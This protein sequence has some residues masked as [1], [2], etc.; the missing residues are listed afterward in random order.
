M[1]TV[2]ASLFHESS[3]RCARSK[4]VLK[5]KLQVGQSSQIQWV[6]EAVIIIDGCAM[7]WTVVHWATSGTVED[8][9]INFIVNIHYHLELGDVYLIFD[10]DTGNSTKQIAIYS[11]SDN[12]TS[13][14]HQLSL[15]TTLPTQNNN[16][17]LINLICHFL[18]NHIKD[19]KTKRVTTGKNQHRYKIGTIPFFR[20]M[21]WKQTTKKPMLSAYITLLELRQTHVLS[22]TSRKYAAIPMSLSCWFTFISIKKMTMNVSMESP[23]AGRTI[24]DIRQTALK[25]QHIIKYMPAVYD[26]TGC[27]TPSYMFGIGKATALKVLTGGHHL[28]ELGQRGAN[29]DKLI[30]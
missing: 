7:L 17:Q 22:R 6:Y 26:L 4:A 19:N 30:H 21:I 14:K 20:E 18:I 27:D 28:I 13:R 5:T 11:R 10:R 1:S 8:Y 24:I 9:I 15:H 23:C 2:P 16:I 12:G 29:E 25:H 3:T